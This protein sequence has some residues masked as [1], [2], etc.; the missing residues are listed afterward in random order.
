MKNHIDVT[1]LQDL[2]DDKWHLIPI[3]E[4]K[5]VFRRYVTNIADEQLIDIFNNCFINDYI[6]NKV[7]SNFFSL[8]WNECVDGDNP[9]IKKG[10]YTGFDLIEMIIEKHETL[11]HFCH[12]FN[13]TMSSFS[14]KEFIFPYNEQMFIC[15]RKKM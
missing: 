8:K 4:A 15:C 10:K 5:D 1:C 12:C 6:V 13:Y 11:A 2:F 7:S 3:E 9:P 14:G